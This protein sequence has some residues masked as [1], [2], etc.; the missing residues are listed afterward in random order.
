M[1]DTDSTSSYKMSAEKKIYPVYNSAN[2][3]ITKDVIEKMLKKGDVNIPIGDIEIWQRAFI[4]TSYC[5][6]NDFVKNEK[7]YGTTMDVKEED[8]KRAIPLQKDSNEVL[9]WLGDGVIQSVVA[10]YLVK[11]FPKEREGFLTKIRSKLVKTQSLSKLAHFLEMDKY[12]MISKH[13]EIICNGRKSDTILEDAFEAFVGAL[14]TAFGDFTLCYTFVV[15]CIDSVI[16]ITEL[17]MYDDNYKDQLMRLYQRRYN[18][19]CPKYEQKAI[20]LNTDK[21]GIVH[22]NFHMFV[23]DINNAIIGEGV[24][25][26][27]KAAEQKAAEEALKF[28]G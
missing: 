25:K 12:L 11:R 9:E 14:M 28:L 6:T 16:D 20:I 5:S 2:V 8:I 18:G 4:H 24:A 22:K 19:V 10:I 17:I 7:F 13:V 3:Y 23:R 15:K 26:S 21:N 1:S 27:K